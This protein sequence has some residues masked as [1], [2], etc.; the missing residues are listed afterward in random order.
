MTRTDYGH[1]LLFVLVGLRMII[2]SFWTTVIMIVVVQVPSDL[3]PSGP[4][5]PQ[6]PQQ[7]H[8]RRH[9]ADGGLRVRRPAHGGR[10]Q[11]LQVRPQVRASDTQQSLSCGW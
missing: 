6:H 9:L 4:L 7:G 5:R 8:H 1:S 2:P 11:T 10:V 3:L